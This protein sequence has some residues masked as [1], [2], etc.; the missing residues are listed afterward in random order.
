MAP[1]KKNTAPAISATA[2]ALLASV[3]TATNAGNVH[4]IPASEDAKFLVD[5]G[6]ITVDTGNVNANGEA[7]ASATEKGIKH[8]TEN[9]NT[10]TGNT[11]AAA[12]AEKPK[13]EIKSIPMPAARRSPVGATSIYPFDDLPAPTE[14]GNVSAFFVPATA[15]RPEP[16]KTLASTVSSA[17]KR[18][19]TKTGEENYTTGNGETKT[20]GVFDYSRKFRLTAGEEN[21]VKGAYVARVK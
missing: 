20:R 19:A 17:S 10:G 16:W 11:T 12:P 15:D 13:F 4:M 9:S 14:D 1:R 6:F 8:M 5:N 2:L 18:Y 3:V 7:A 21:G